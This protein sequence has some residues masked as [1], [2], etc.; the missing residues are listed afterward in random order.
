MAAK[1]T[2]EAVPGSNPSTKVRRLP[3]P[4]RFLVP[5]LVA[6]LVCNQD[7]AKAVE[8]ALNLGRLDC[9]ATDEA[10]PASSLRGLGGAI[11]RR[12]SVIRQPGANLA[13]QIVVRSAGGTYGLLLPD[14]EAQQM[15]G[16]RAVRSRIEFVLHFHRNHR[17]VAD[18]A[19]PSRAVTGYD[20]SA[21][22]KQQATGEQVTNRL[23]QR[24][25]RTTRECEERIENAPA[26]RNLV[27]RDPEEGAVF[28]AV[29]PW[30]ALTSSARR[31]A[32]LGLLGCSQ[33]KPAS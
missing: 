6:R 19:A 18:D 31:S 5:E 24:R 30:S 3:A 1:G 27:A 32:S 2:S 14:L 16:H 26:T 13:S 25:S 22:Q 10:R 15:A 11:D 23:L 8:F 21:N 9:A 12:Q 7:D 4:D 28:V 33:R 29:Q 17:L 20:L